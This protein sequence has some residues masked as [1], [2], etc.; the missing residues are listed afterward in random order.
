MSG[1][2]ESEEGVTVVP[3]IQFISIP[4]NSLRVLH[5]SAKC[6]V[7]L[8][9]VNTAASVITTIMPADG[10]VRNITKILLFSPNF[11]LTLITYGLLSYSV[12]LYCANIHTPLPF[13]FLSLR[14]SDYEDKAS[15]SIL[16]GRHLGQ[17]FYKSW[18]SSYSGPG[19]APSSNS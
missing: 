11:F 17:L 18:L 1:N 9:A 5:Q 6:R 10:V 16:L 12:R 8:T 3:L 15:R 14:F 2:G 7:R 19:S 4:A 13:S